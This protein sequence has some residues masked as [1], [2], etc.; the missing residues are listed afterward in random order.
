MNKLLQKWNTT[1]WLLVRRSE[2]E[3]CEEAR[4]RFGARG[5]A[6][7][8]GIQL[9][10]AI[11]TKSNILLVAPLS[12]FC[13][14]HAYRKVYT[15]LHQNFYFLEGELFKNKNE[16]TAVAR[17]IFST[18]ITVPVS[19]NIYGKTPL[20]FVNHGQLLKNVWR[21]DQR[22][23]DGLTLL[24]PHRASFADTQPPLLHLNPSFGGSEITSSN[25]ISPVE[26]YVKGC[27]IPSELVYALWSVAVGCRSTAP[28]R[29]EWFFKDAYVH[30]PS[31]SNANYVKVLGLTV[32]YLLLENCIFRRLATLT[33]TADGKVSFGH[34]ND[35]AALLL[36]TVTGFDCPTRSLLKWL[37]ELFQVTDLDEEYLI[38]LKVYRHQCANL[39]KKKLNESGYY[40]AIHCGDTLK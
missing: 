20:R 40:D 29:C 28:G 25:V 36:T 33:C 8:L 10:A 31:F 38:R 6:A 21:V 35:S 19:L 4:G 37:G 32:L 3:P 7:S 27:R 17:F 18:D 11:M 22:Q 24:A 30:V 34:L 26:V 5:F 2:K 39:I 15:M 14:K 1:E 12:L 16:R 23:G 9:E 13:N